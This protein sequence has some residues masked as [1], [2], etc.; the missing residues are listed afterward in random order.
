MVFMKLLT[1]Y[2]QSPQL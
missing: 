2:Y 1:T